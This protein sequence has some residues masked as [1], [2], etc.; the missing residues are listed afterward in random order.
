VV[1]R[2]EQVLRAAVTGREHPA[3]VPPSASARPSPAR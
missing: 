1:E 3:I 2:L